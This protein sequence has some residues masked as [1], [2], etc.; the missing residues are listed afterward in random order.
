MKSTLTHW[1]KISNYKVSNYR[2]V[3]KV[4]RGFQNLEKEVELI[5][6]AEQIRVVSI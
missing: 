3:F 6:F 1:G 2:N 4:V 5:F